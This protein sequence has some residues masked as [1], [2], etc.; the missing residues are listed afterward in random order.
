MARQPSGRDLSNLLPGTEKH[1]CEF[2]CPDGVV[3]FRL[4]AIAKKDFK[5]EPINE[6]TRQKVSDFI[7]EHWHGTDMLIRAKIIDRT[8]VDGFVIF[9]EGVII[10]L[11]TFLLKTI[12]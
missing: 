10:G 1:K 8:K 7:A 11:V 6:S 9:K 5:P 4:E 3:K 2:T 12:L